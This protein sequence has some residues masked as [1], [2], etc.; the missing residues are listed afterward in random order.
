MAINIDPGTTTPVATD[1]V[2]GVHYQQVKLVAG[3]DDST[4]PIAGDAT[5][6][7][8]VDVTR[9]SGTVTTSDTATQVDD[10]IF[11]PGTGRVM[12][13]GATLDDTTPDT[14]NEGDGG[15]VRMTADRSLH[16]SIR[17]SAGNNRGVNVDANNRLAVDGT[18]AGNVAH[19]AVDAGGPVKV[20]ARAVAVGASP[21]AVAAGDRTD[22]IANR[23]GVPYV[24][25][26]HPN[27]VSLEAAYTAATTNEP[28]IT[29]GAGVRIVVTQIQVTADNANTVDVGV[30]IGFGA[31]TTPTTTG[32]VLSHPGIAP[33]SGVSRGD[34]SGILG[35]GADGEDL[36][37]TSEVPTTGSIR[38]V[39]SYYTLEG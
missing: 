25:G 36:R 18:V 30:R 38:V 17:D 28:I 37:I 21:A 23:H 16:I 8:D 5:N 11:V 31:T 13:I 9:V 12:M 22:L 1:D 34:G 3:Q 26:G 2:A 15:A 35:I 39:V 14:V 24:M 29:V 4:A 33:G 6:G 7:L 10:V 32:V 19:D 27:I 20:G